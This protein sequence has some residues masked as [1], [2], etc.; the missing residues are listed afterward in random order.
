[1]E[2]RRVGPKEAGNARRPPSSPRTRPETPQSEA[3]L[4]WVT[5][6]VPPDLVREIEA[7]AKRSGTTRS[8]AIRECLAVGIETLRYRDG[9]PGGRVDEL[10][11]A[12]E[13]VRLLLELLGPPTFGTQRL[14]AHWASRDR[15]VKVSEEELM[16]EV[17][18]VSADEWEQAVA[19]AERD[20]S[21]PRNVGPGDEEA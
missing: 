8:E 1:M 9:V 5:A 17:R 6:R 16:A 14:L 2:L 3:S 20:L 12:I 10:L 18:V 21:K 13:S 15:A 11:G 19:D 7:H 4:Q